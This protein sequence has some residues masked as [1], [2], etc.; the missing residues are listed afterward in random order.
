MRPC[1]VG[2]KQQ[3]EQ[4]RFSG[5][6]SAVPGPRN[7]N[8]NDGTDDGCLTAPPMVPSFTLPLTEAS[9]CEEPSSPHFTSGGA[10]QAWQCPLL[11]GSGDGQLR[12]GAVSCVQAGKVLPPGSEITGRS[13]GGGDPARTLSLGSLGPLAT[14]R[15]PLQLRQGLRWEPW[16]L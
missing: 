14:H 15:D 4:I 6:P 10:R 2:E 16:P 3:Q 7:H 11:A 8:S 12:G 9:P 1:Q 13:P 5:A